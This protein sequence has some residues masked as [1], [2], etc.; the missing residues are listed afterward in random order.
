MSIRMLAIELYQTMKQVGELEKELKMLA[1]D[2]PARGQV[3]NNLRLAKAELNRLK[4]MLE[5]A[6]DNP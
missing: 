5:G 1:S 6:K 3:E 2:A 4:A